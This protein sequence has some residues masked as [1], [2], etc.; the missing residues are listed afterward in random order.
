MS[1]YVGTTQTRSFD[2]ALEV[3]E[4]ET[5][6]PQVFGRMFPIGVR[7][8]VVAHEDGQLVEYDEEFLPGCTVRM[9][10]R[11]RPNWIT[12]TIDHRQ[13]MD[14]RLGT[15]VALDERRDGV[16]G[17]FELYD[18]GP[19]LARVRSI[20]SKSHT[21]LSIEFRDVVAPIIEGSTRKRRQIHVDA[22]SATPVPVY[23]TAGILA[24][25]SDGL[26]DA[27]GATPRLDQTRAL[28]QSLS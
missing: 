5:G 14:S 9:R 22:V 19:P 28:L 1:R 11:S 6:L 8:H 17:T 10:Q 24:M 16:Y 3:R 20:L 12:L 18:E 2:A 4:P 21:G 23:E 26:V 15:C 13:D 7:A 25:R 27:L